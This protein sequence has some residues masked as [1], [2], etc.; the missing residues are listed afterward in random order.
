MKRF[1]RRFGEGGAAS[2]VLPVLLILCMLAAVISVGAR[3]LAEDR[4][5]V[6]EEA[7]SGLDLGAQVISQ[8]LNDLYVSLDAVAP[9]LAFEAGFTQAQM[10][11]AM[12][13]LRDACGFDY[14]VRT[15]TN[16]IA[17]NYLGRENIDLSGRQYIRDALRGLRTCEYVDSGTYDPGSA[18]IILA[19]PVFY[20]DAVVGVL[21][22]SY[23]VSNFDRML[24]RSADGGQSRSDGTFIIAEDGTVIGASDR[25]ADCGPFVEVLLHRS[26]AAGAEAAAAALDAGKSG[27]LLQNAD[28]KKQYVYYEPLSGIETCRWVMITEVDQATVAE[29][30]RATGYGIAM[31]YAAAFCI[32]VALICSVILRQRLAV[33][34]RNEARAL[35]EA[36]SDARAASRAKSDFLSRM[37]H[38]IRTPLNGIIGMTYL[39]QEMTL[40]EA[41][42]SNLRKIATS[43]KFL[44]GLVNDILDMSKTERQEITL[45][46]EPYP[47]E[48]FS[49]Y[50]DAVI[51]PL[52]AEKRQEFRFEAEPIRGYV[53]VVDIMKLNQ[54][55]FNL[56]SNAVKYTPEGGTISLKIREELLTDDHIRFTLTVSDNGIGMSEE[57]QKSMFEPFTQENRNDASP[58][59]GS[60]LGLAI[61]RRTVE[62]MGGT[63][64]VRSRENEGSSF[65]VSI[66]SPCLKR[67]ALE[68]KAAESAGAASAQDFSAL[69][70]KHI[71]LCEDHPLNQE[72]AR[73]LLNEKGMLVQLAEDGQK[74]LDAFSKAPVGYYDCI[75]MDLRMPVLD[76]YETTKAIR[77]LSRAD[78]GTVPI[79]AMTADAFDDDVQKC[80]DAGMNGHIAKPIEPELMY[81]AL[82]RLIGGRD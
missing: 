34:Q 10:L 56:L 82:Q 8:K 11:R 41:A 69:A 22:G 43:S 68:K 75:L 42:Q 27:Y 32:T 14:V 33:L 16:G 12:T 48:D 25:S 65:T 36:L 58:S 47:F 53:P 26:D 59:R 20:G 60:G 18:Y 76:G 61:V 6:H 81:A 31:L 13:A 55:Y 50:L 52:C 71:L 24:S 29:H 45:H 51:R 28:G 64:R 17:F 37:S 72:I 63:L 2:Y 49:A 57:F 46:P 78:A 9:G 79:V 1:K 39:T 67:A 77:G 66:V 80:F 38:D 35:S 44:L 74:G 30:T 23:K 19:V 62:A 54:I 5:H 40:P 4:R 73:A 70:G 7:L 15:D 21:H 3:Q